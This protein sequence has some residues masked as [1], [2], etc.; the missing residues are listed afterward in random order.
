L[1]VQNL[2]DPATP[3]VGSLGLR[4]VLGPAAATVDVDQGGHAAYLLTASA[5]ANDT[6]TAFLAHGV[7]PAG[8]YRLCPG[9]APPA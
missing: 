2:R 3:W 4:R 9:Q 5:C 8:G 7:L 6:V 1:I